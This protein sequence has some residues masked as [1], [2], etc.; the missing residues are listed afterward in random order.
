[1]ISINTES[2]FRWSQFFGL[3]VLGAILSISFNFY[4]PLE[5]IAD[6]MFH[7]AQILLFKSSKYMVIQ[8][9]TV[10]PA[11]HLVVAEIA[12]IFGVDTFSGVR[13]VSGL[14]SFFAIVMSY[15]YLLRA[16]P[17]YPLIGSLQ[18]LSAPLLCPFFWLLYTDISSLG[19]TLLSLV[20]LIDRRYLMCALVCGVSLLFRQHN[21][22]WVV[23]VFFMALGQLQ[24]WA[25]LKGNFAERNKPWAHNLY[26]LLRV[27]FYRIW[28]FLIPLSGF[29]IFIFLNEG[30][31]LGDRQNQKFSGIYPLQ[32]FLFLLVM[33]FV[34]LPL[35]IS[36]LPK[37]IT[38]LKK[39]YWIILGLIILGVVFLKTFKI[40]HPHNFPSEY[41]LRNWF[42]YYLDGHFHL[43]LLAYALIA[44]TMLSLM[45]TQLRQKSDY[46]LY[47][48]IFIA[49][50]PVSLI[51]QRYY[52]VPFCLFMLFRR[53]LSLRFEI[54]LLLWF[55]I[56]SL[57]LMRGI[58][59]LMF[60]L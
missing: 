48:L 51:E 9:L 4:L 13:L 5:P 41:F 40:T 31:A 46:W 15:F 10:P 49:L 44:Y 12:K 55:V 14:C 28:P 27:I 57:Y 60:F 22:F 43:K 58:V 3:L 54:L 53:P 45:V 23:L 11:Y 34:L 50:L 59:S 2:K 29:A 8:E 16:Q 37:I 25:H 7:L 35:H 52:I 18:L 6:E 39:N 1:M 38:L 19:V 21:I 42:L 17:S 30:V 24:I 56:C 33:G 47:P 26:G 36:N 32:I 20:L